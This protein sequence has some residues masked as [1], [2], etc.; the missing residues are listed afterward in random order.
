[1][2]DLL[3]LLKQLLPPDAVVMTSLRQLRSVLGVKRPA[4]YCA[5]RSG[6]CFLR[7]QDPK[8]D[9]SSC[10]PAA[11]TTLGLRRSAC[12]MGLW[13]LSQ[14]GRYASLTASSTEMRAR[15]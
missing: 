3:P 5:C 9:P 12:P 8:A 4:R 13:A 15:G 2:D 14:L 6:K 11:A 7:P 10:L 1:M